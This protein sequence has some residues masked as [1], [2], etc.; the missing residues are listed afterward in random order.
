[1]DRTFLE[2]NIQDSGDRLSDALKRIDHLEAQ[3]SALIKYG[4]LPVSERQRAGLQQ[5][6]LRS[7]G[8]QSGDVGPTAPEP[9]VY[10][11]EPEEWKQ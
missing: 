11:Y 2:L 10:Q 5:D 4:V 8:E 1:M 3:V 7:P 9:D 6:T